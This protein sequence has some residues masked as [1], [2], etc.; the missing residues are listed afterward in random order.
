MLASP[1]GDPKTRLEKLSQELVRNAG[2][3]SEQSGETGRYLI[4]D[5]RIAGDKLGPVREIFE[6]FDEQAKAVADSGNPPERGETTNR[7]PPFSTSEILYLLQS[8][9]DHRE[10]E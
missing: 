4:S 3:I 10:S 5:A 1:V 7:D 8:L 6:L 9:V 2:L